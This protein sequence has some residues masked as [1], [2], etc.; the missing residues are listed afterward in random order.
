MSGLSPQDLRA[1]VEDMKA[2][3]RERDDDADQ[4]NVERF[5]GVNARLDKV[6]GNIAR[7]EREIAAGREAQAAADVRTKN[8][9]REVFGARQRVATQDDEKPALTKGGVKRALAVLAALGVAM[10][11]LHQIANVVI[12]ALRHKP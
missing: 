9:E 5:A 7:H 8:L 10:E 3:I 1:A 2:Y 4:R 11:A 6:N 12:A